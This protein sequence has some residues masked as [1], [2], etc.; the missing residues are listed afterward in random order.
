MKTLFLKELVM[1]NK[2]MTPE[3]AYQELERNNNF[4]E[5]EIFDLE[6]IVA[7]SYFFS[8]GYAENILEGIF[9]LGDPIID[10]RVFWEGDWN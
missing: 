8:Y 7:Q 1:E 3:E 10:L 6:C 9:R 2:L 5:E 4:S